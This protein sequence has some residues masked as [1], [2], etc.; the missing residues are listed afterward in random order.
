MRAALTAHQVLTIQPGLSPETILTHF[1][2]RSPISAMPMVVLPQPGFAHQTQANRPVPDETRT[3]FTARW[4]PS[5]VA[6][7]DGQVVDFQ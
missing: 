3:S 4:V 7:T 5:A 6:I 1:D 2:A